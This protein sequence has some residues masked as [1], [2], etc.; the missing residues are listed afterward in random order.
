MS[1]DGR[2]EFEDARKK[3]LRDFNS[4]KFSGDN[5]YLPALDAILTNET[6]VSEVQL[7][8]MEIPVKKI[9]G[10]K[11]V[12]RAT[13]FAPNF[14]PILA[15][16]TEFSS[17]W[18]HLCNAHL[19]EG[20]RDPI[21]VYEYLNWFYVEEGNKRV[22]VLKYNDAVLMSAEVT[23]LI[24]KYDP[25]DETNVIYYEFLDFFKQTRLNFI[26]MSERGAFNRLLRQMH[27]YQWIDDTKHT[28]F[29]AFYYRFRRLYHDL[30]GSSINITTG[31]A[32]L[33][34]LEVYAYDTD[35][36]N[37]QIR[38]QVMNMWNEFKLLA[39]DEPIALEVSP[40]VLEKKSFFDGITNF[41][42][43]M[44]KAKIA[45]IHSKSAEDSVWT[46]GHEIGRHHLDNVF[47]NQVETTA[48]NNI[49]EDERAYDY[50]V[51]VVKAGYDIVFTTTPTY[52]YPTLKAAVEFK[53]VKFLNC[54]ENMSYRNVRTYFGR[55]H[56]PNF[57]VGM[58]A[59]A[60]TAT[61]KL[62]YVVTY[63]IPEV[64]S[65]INAFTLGARFVNPYVTVQVKWVSSSHGEHDDEE[66]YSIN[67]QL[68]DMGVD[69]ISHQES[70]DLTNK[71]NNSGI[72][73]VKD[74][75]QEH[76]H[77]YLATPLWNWGE[78][79]EKIVRNIMSGAYNKL[80]NSMGSNDQAI[81]YWWGLD[82]Q[83]VD[84]FYSKSK[85]PKSII[86]S[87]E[88][89]KEMIIEGRYHPFRGPL[90]DN[91]GNLRFEEKGDLPASDILTMDWFVDG[92]L[93]SIPT[94]KVMDKSHPLLELMSVKKKY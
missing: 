77:N 10:T 86:E 68:M 75:D 29:R 55:I 53:D 18:M 91:K 46:Y 3:G 41:S 23:R 24:P 58:I 1:I 52:I 40:E 72:Y 49:P 11:T 90:Y 79:Y 2:V 42:S 45:F 64:I 31:D 60:M 6:I 87:V 62:G 36:K 8:L 15:I 28:E 78:F 88:F 89:M 70:S 7:G 16:K 37:D 66:T 83:V 44:K 84:V 71:L 17:K 51:D 19:A 27:K 38:R 59:G 13:S 56:E 33:K 39:H 81:S 4:H 63:P 5:P 30:G 47:G 20:I 22:S 67:K 9:K 12:G 74:D 34:Y 35:I 80:S 43:G 93:G 85:L 26:W 21:K 57:L 25:T 61:N 76:R 48:F 92:V 54:S 32:F 82:T 94:I 69:I 65:S 73:F 50:I 14:M